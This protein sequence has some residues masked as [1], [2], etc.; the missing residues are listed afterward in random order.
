MVATHIT[1]TAVRHVYHR[2]YRWHAPQWMRLAGGALGGVVA[3]GIAW[4][5]YVG[6]WAVAR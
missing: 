3:L 1:D 5:L 2:R 4:A 6:L